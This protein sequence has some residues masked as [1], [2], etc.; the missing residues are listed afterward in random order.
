MTT[1]QSRPDTSIRS[2]YPEISIDLHL[3]DAVVDLVGDGFDAALRIAVLPDSSLVAR[4]LC[5]VSPVVLAAPSY[6]A[7]HG[8]PR[9][10]RELNGHHCLG[11]AY[12]RRQDIWHFTNRAGEEESVTPSGQL[13]VTNADALVP[14][15][16]EGLAIAELPE[17]MAAE[18]LAE[19]RLTAILTDWSLPKGGLYFITPSARTR[20]AKVGVLAD[21]LIDRLSEP[22]WWRRDDDPGA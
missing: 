1:V 6:L 12:R 22:L 10:P 21:F 3:S 7:R 20:P 15:L 16:L 9:H 4:R 8:E 14:M 19:G 18:H 5:G 11:Y 17:F 13:R 2:T